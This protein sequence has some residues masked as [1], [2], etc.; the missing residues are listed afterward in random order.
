M[1]YLQRRNSIL[2]RS[3]KYAG[4]LS[5]QQRTTKLPDDHESNTNE[6]QLKIL[7][8]N[9]QIRFTTDDCDYTSNDYETIIPLSSTRSLT[10]IFYSTSEFRQIEILEV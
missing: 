3:Q 2:V 9:D 7:T 4:T 8:V 5:K 6:Q 1:I 10:K